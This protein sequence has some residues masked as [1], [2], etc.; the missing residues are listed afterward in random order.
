MPRFGAR[1]TAE[2]LARLAT[3]ARGLPLPPRSSG[4]GRYPCRLGAAAE[5]PSACFLD[6]RLRDWG[7]LKALA[8]TVAATTADVAARAPLDATW[9]PAPPVAGMPLSLTSLRSTLLRLLRWC[10]F[11]RTPPPLPEFASPAIE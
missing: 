4:S 1:R 8:N 9:R 7:R 2:H 11:E 3:S 5:P 10:L 6:A